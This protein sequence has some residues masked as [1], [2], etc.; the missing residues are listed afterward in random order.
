MSF[1][2]NHLSVC[3]PPRMSAQALEAL[4]GFASGIN[5][6]QHL[7][8][9]K[10]NNV[11]EMLQPAV[12]GL[13]TGLLSPKELHSAWTSSDPMTAFAG[14][15]RTLAA[16][17]KRTLGP[18]ID[19]GPDYET[20]DLLL[21]FDDCPGVELT[22]GSGYLA[23]S[24]QLVG[25]KKPYRRIVAAIAHR[26]ISPALASSAFEAASN[27]WSLTNLLAEVRRVGLKRAM[28]IADRVQ[29][30]DQLMEEA[31]ADELPYAH[32]N[33][34]ALARTYRTLS[35]EERAIKAI[36]MSP[37][38][39]S[40]RLDALNRSREPSSIKRWAREAAEFLASPNN[41]PDI[42]CDG[43]DIPIWTSMVVSFTGHGHQLV[44]DVWQADFESG[45]SPNLRFTFE[46][47]STPQFLIYLQR[48]KRAR[49]L[50]CQ[51]DYLGSH[52]E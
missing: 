31:Y 46:T 48:I 44:D 33:G 22:M 47:A 42:E 36:P 43:Y 29:Q 52:L 13:D 28:S 6:N 35:A 11:M 39:F 51:I 16:R 2:N 7:T 45:E 38:D 32:F 14:L 41:C 26:L 49:E 9:L 15:A 34:Q 12:W 3:Q 25:V 18:T 17:L 19:L 4:N 20:P 23:A 37:E 50:L 27:A 21:R 1:F 10:P 40:Q 24:I 5:S 8:L 30:D